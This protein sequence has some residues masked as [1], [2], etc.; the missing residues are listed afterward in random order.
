M[1]CRHGASVSSGSRCGSRTDTSRSSKW[2][3]T[4]IRAHDMAHRQSNRF[5]VANLR[6]DAAAT[7][8]LADLCAKLRAFLLAYNHSDRFTGADVRADSAQ[9]QF[10]VFVR[11][12]AAATHLLADLCAKLRAFPLAY[13]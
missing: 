10:L 4:V 5:Y 2:Q 8:L 6:A 9:F 3:C 12:D 11:A 7:H 13:N 1:Q